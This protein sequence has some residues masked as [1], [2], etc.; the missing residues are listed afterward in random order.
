MIYECEDS[1]K[2]KHLERDKYNMKQILGTTL[3]YEQSFCFIIRNSLLNFYQKIN[4]NIQSNKYVIFL[5]VIKSCKVN[6]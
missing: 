5:F 6:C 1:M 4:C 2:D 3:N